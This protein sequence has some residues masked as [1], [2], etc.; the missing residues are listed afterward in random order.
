M[1]RRLS[2]RALCGLSAVAA[3]S[4]TSSLQAGET[5]GPVRY[6]SHDALSGGNGSIDQPWTLDE[7]QDQLTSGMTLRLRAG[8]Y[9][10]KATSWPSGLT[11]VVVEGAPE[12]LPDRPV[13]R[14]DRI[15]PPEDWA[16]ASDGAFRAFV[17]EP[18]FSVVWNWDENLTEE[19]PPRKPRHFG[20]LV[21]RSSQAEVAANPGSW[22]WNAAE[23]K[24]WISPP[25]GAIDPDQGDTYAY[26][27]GSKAF[28]FN[29]WSNSIVREINTALWVQADGQNGYSFQWNNAQNCLTEKS[30]IQGCGRHAVGYIGGGPTVNNIM[31]HI[32]VIGANYD[33]SAPTTNPFVFAGVDNDDGQA[34]S[35]NR[36]EDLAFHASPLVGP[37][38]AILTELWDEYKPLML[39]SHAEAPKVMGGVT[40]L[41]PT[42]IGY[43]TPASKYTTRLVAAHNEPSRPTQTEEKNPSAYPIRVIEPSVIATSIGDLHG[44]IAF[45]RGSFDLL[46]F[47]NANN[48]TVAIF[49]S[50][51]KTAL[52]E[53]CEFAWDPNNGFFTNIF[54]INH[55]SRL[56]G[57]LTTFF[58]LTADDGVFLARPVS[59]DAGAD[60]DRCVFAYESASVK[61]RLLNLIPQ[62]NPEL[63]TFSDCWYHNIDDNSYG[64]GDDALDEESE[65]QENK[66]PNGVYDLDPQFADPANADLAPAPNGALRTTVDFDADFIDALGIAGNPYSGHYGAYQFGGVAD[67]NGDEAVD[68][69][70]LG[71]MLGAWGA[72]PALEQPC[73]ADL[74]FDGAVTGADLG[75]LLGQ[76]SNK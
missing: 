10:Q 47:P 67:L 14:G 65:W 48:S 37:D 28:L 73:P 16:S 30:E 6:V 72:C 74:D 66:D 51:D 9:R 5:D 3:M 75:L 44:N 64:F 50:F 2:T 68:G 31:R 26:C 39:N 12:D 46:N 62:N 40:W 29:G 56:V 4:L 42:L 19:T 60:F 32:T 61:H 17:D 49:H 21:P 57:T 23:N 24:L 58:I 22:W 52:F 69:A 43:A 35:G 71:L 34:D 59:V 55:T 15:V 63:W 20:H 41:R 45:Q 11:D 38:G 53:A 7:A 33:D 18:V 13:V 36:G 8:V 70:D 76:W 1:N 27:V 25:P 54:H